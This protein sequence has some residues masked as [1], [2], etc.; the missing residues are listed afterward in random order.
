MKGKG[1]ELGMNRSLVMGVF[2]YLLTMFFSPVKAQQSVP[3]L[4][5]ST[6]SEQCNRA[7]DELMATMTLEEKIGQLFMVVIYPSSQQY[8]IAE[9]QTLLKSLH[10]GGVLF[11]KGDAYDQYVLTNSLQANAKKVGFLVAADNEWGL[12]MRLSSTIRYPRNMALQRCSASEIEQ[13]GRDVAKQCHTIGVHISFAP[14]LDVNNNPLNPVIGTRSFGERP[15]VVTKLGLSYARGLEEQGVMAVAK[16]FP[17]H[18]NTSVDSH[19]ALPTITANKKQLNACELVPFSAFINAGYGGIMVGHLALPAIE[20][21]KSV[22]A[23]LSKTITT[24]VLKHEMG[25][26]GLVFTDGLAMAG[27]KTVKG[28]PLG[29][30]AILAGNNILVGSANPTQ[31]FNDVL[32]AVRN[33]VIPI[34]LVEHN[35]RAILK[36]KWALWGGAFKPQKVNELAKTDFYNALNGNGL[37]A[38]ADSLWLRSID[39]KKYV[40]DS[41]FAKLGNKPIGVVSFVGEGKSA[42]G[43]FENTLKQLGYNKVVCVNIPSNIKVS[44]PKS[45]EVYAT[46]LLACDVIF[47]NAYNKPTRSNGAIINELVKTHSVY[48]SLF[49][50]PYSFPSWKEYLDNVKG[51]AIANENCIEATRAV[52]KRWLTPLQKLPIVEVPGG[53]F[54][55]Q[56]PSKTLAKRKKHSGYDFSVVDSLLEE[57]IKTRA[58]PGCQVVVLYKGNLVYN[59]S[60]GQLHYASNASLVCENTLYDVASIT[61][62][63][64]TTPAVMMLVDDGKIKLSQQICTILPGLENTEVGTVS[65]KE[66]LLHEGGLPATIN[67]YTRLI[68]STSLPQN[69]FFFYHAG[70]GLTQIDNH[71]WVPKNFKFSQE[72]LSPE[73]RNG[74]DRKFS[75][76]YYIAN[77]FRNEMVKRISEIT[78]VGRG[79]RKYSDVGFILLG[80]VVEQIT[81]KPL[82]EFVTECLYR[83]M[84][85][86]HITF[87]PLQH[88]SKT[89]I[90]PTQENNFLRGKVWG[91]VDDENAACLGGIAGNAGVFSNAFDLAK[92]GLLFMDKGAWGKR[93][94]ISPNTVSLFCNTLGK[95]GKR[96]LGFEK[97]YPNNPNV[98]PQA[99]SQ[100]FGHTGFTGTCLWVDPKNDLVYVFLSNRTYPSRNN[101]QLSISR[102]RPRLM[103]AIY[104][105]LL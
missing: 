26:K 70:K 95:D 25:F 93:D 29:V 66:L 32:T 24:A 92:M 23:S 63:V 28:Y 8:K 72:F 41:L 97:A 74:F 10:A 65:V 49:D 89:L 50:S 48:F 53:N 27:A 86:H 88:Y 64:A 68:D 13:Y 14:V 85:L 38:R 16:H 76:S 5:R 101:N 12:A 52:I 7:V 75:D 47:V 100:T 15:D 69:K 60:M 35:C 99:S 102:L 18:G 39:V 37:V 77:S 87:Q 45:A 30:E 46:K 3:T 73:K 91:V 98:S 62:M 1:K 42:Q 83:P 96:A 67:F 9:A 55:Q 17:G 34:Q 78:L 58:Y 90:A 54:Q 36:A 84:E 105:A 6:N 80:L 22:P 31:M 71:V 2:V 94:L 20:K 56:V 82:N 21:H 43:S 44:S 81:G 79:T 33:G 57:G 11:Q 104:D 59:K 103:D 4:L 19:K 61:K 51:I 40:N